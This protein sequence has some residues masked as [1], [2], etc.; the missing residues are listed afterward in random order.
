MNLKGSTKILQVMNMS[1]ECIST[2]AEEKD[3]SSEQTT[4]LKKSSCAGKKWTMNTS[5]K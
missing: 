2:R 3:T 4:F 1:E 5:K